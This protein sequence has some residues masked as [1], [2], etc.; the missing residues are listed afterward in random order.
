MMLQSFG[1]VWISLVGSDGDYGQLGIQALEN[2]ATKKGICIAFKGIMPSSALPGDESM[3]SL[4]HSLAQA[5]TTVVVVFSARQPAWVFF[6][7]VVLANLTAKVWLASE[8]WAISRHISRVPGIWAIGTVLGVAIQQKTV[9]GL[10]EFEEAYVRADKVASQ[11]CS[12]GSKCGA[13]QLCRE[14]QAFTEHT[15]PTLAAFSM[16]SA[17]NV[18]QAVYAVAH[19]LH[20][21]L[22]CTSG[23]CSRGHVYPEQVRQSSPWHPVAGCFPKGRKVATVWSP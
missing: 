1:W 13:S 9:P 12:R 20:H 3:Q 21:L 15:M 11:A 5:R 7:S 19:G 10:K 6:E 17:S 23:A 8:D 14:C 18:Y 4:V 22:G 16:S 2:Q